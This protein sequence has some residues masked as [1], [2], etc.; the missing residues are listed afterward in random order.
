MVRRFV[1]L[2]LDECMKLVDP[3][4]VWNPVPQPASQGREETRAS[5]ERWESDWE[6]YE[7]VPEDLVAI[8][9]RVLVT[10]RF[11]GRGRRSGVEVH[12]R[13]YELFTVREGKIV[14]M[15]EFTERSEAL[16]AAGLSE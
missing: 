15:D 4:I 6:E 8:D 10:L 16:Q 13:M 2:D 3:A 1:L 7:E 14:R 12:T 5:I 11:R 9:D